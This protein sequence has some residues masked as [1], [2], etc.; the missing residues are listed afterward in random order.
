MLQAKLVDWET[1]AKCSNRFKNIFNTA[2]FLFLNR[3]KVDEI[4][5]VLVSKGNSNK[6]AVALGVDSEGRMKCP[7]SAPFGYMETLSKEQSIEN[8]EQALYEIEKILKEAGYKEIYITMPP[9]FYE[10]SVIES[11]YAIFINNKWTI[12]YA[13]INFS[14]NILEMIDGYESKIYRNARKNLRIANSKKMKIKECMSEKERI[15]AYQIIK[16]NRAAKGYPLKMSEEQVLKTMQIIPSRM[17]RVM[18]EEEA[19]A[20]ALVYDV[21]DKIAQVVYWG[22]IPGKSNLKVMNFIAYELIKYYGERKFEYLDIGPS[23][24]YGVPNYGLC[25]FKDSIGC[26]RSVKYTFMKELK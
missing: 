1:Y 19:I 4:V 25:D 13:D 7:F 11:W 17:F 18:Y 26:E 8:Y 16:A 3:N 20:S 12:R 24:E 10:K 21:T 2:D 6:F 5:Y 23:T 14:I 15:S 9:S 22:D